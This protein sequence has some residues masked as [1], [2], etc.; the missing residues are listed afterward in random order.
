MEREDEIAGLGNSY[1][2]ANRN[3]DSRTARWYSL[4]PAK[5]KYPNKSAYTSFGNNPILYTDPGGDDY[6][7]VI[8]HNAR[9]ITVRACFQNVSEGDAYDA[10]ISNAITTLSTEMNK[11]VYTTN[12]GIEYEIIAD[13][14]V[15]NEHKYSYAEHGPI[16]NILVDEGSGVMERGNE[17][18]GNEHTMKKMNRRSGGGITYFDKIFVYSWQQRNNSRSIMHEIG[19]SLGFLHLLGS[20]IDEETSPPSIKGFTGIMDP[21]ASGLTFSGQGIETML[22]AAGIGKYWFM[23][24]P[25]MSNDKC[26]ASSNFREI[27][28]PS[29]GI[30]RPRAFDG[31]LIE[32]SIFDSTIWDGWADTDGWT[33]PGDVSRT[34]LFMDNYKNA[35]KFSTQTGS[36]KP[37]DWDFID[38]EV[39]QKTQED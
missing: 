1:S 9:T 17:Y 29:Q 26:V 25:Q 3:Y 27:Y 21:L 22:G 10:T 30:G 18:F 2:T 38:G 11:F 19:H 8:N 31:G 33:L 34:L 15:Y 37:V 20:R 24:Y 5:K 6:M 32:D 14:S 35:L 39:S 4:D 13:I 7:L 12:S 36:Q 16:N 28:V 23:R